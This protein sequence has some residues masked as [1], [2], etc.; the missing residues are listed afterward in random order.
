MEINSFCWWVKQFSVT[1]NPKGKAFSK[2]SKDFLP[3]QKVSFLAVLILRTLPCS[4]RERKIKEPKSQITVHLGILCFFF[5][6]LVAFLA[7]KKRIY[8]SCEFD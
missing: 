7:V 8:M 6:I 4:Q 5:F 2:Q 3:G 1:Y